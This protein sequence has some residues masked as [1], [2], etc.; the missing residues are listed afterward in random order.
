[1]T[2]SSDAPLGRFLTIADVA[3][4]LNLTAGEV[5]SL[6]RTGELPG[7]HLGSIG[8]W[9]VDHGVL[10]SFI[11]DKY[12]ESR[13]MAMW[14]EAQYADVAELFGDRRGGPRGGAPGGLRGGSR[15]A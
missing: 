12:D 2:D 10:E 5:L 11:A 6:I 14:Q 13:R 15:G 3:E 9:R 7:I 1:M 4:V 8:Q